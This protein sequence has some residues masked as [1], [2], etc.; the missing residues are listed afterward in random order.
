MYA[1]LK[2][3]VENTPDGGSVSVLFKRKNGGAEIRVT[4]T[5]IGITEESQKYLFGGFFAGEA[6][7]FYSSGKPFVFGAG[8]RGLDPLRIKLHGRRYGLD[9]SV[10]SR[11]CPHLPGGQ[12]QCPGSIERCRRCSGPMDCLESGGTTFSLMFPDVRCATDTRN[13]T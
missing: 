6:L 2:N 3:A 5:G 8:G 9:I 1:L 7:D 13:S 12:D 11:R 10:R 4:D